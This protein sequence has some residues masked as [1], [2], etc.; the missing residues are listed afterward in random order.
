MRHLFSP[1]GDAALTAVMAVRPLLAFDFDGTLAP[2]VARPD[3]A[4][5]PLA[6]AWRLDRLARVLPLAIVS[7]RA[8]DDLRARLPFEPR[9]VIGNHGA[10]DPLA[11]GAV[12]PAALDDVRAQLAAA[13]GALLAAEVVVE[14]KRHSLALHYRL[15]HDRTRALRLITTFV[16]ELGPGVTAFGGKLVMNIV[17]TGAPDKAHAVASLVG[18]SAARAA[19]FLGDDVN[20]EP[21]F[22][23]AET[24]WLTVKVGRDGSASRA[25]Y[26]LDGLADVATMLDRMLGLM[27]DNGIEPSFARA[28]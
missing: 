28:P 12:D 10:E 22:A 4:R 3:A 13:A 6:V 8:V 11:P 7:G 20:D 16:A 9:Y 21:V 14:D 2:L 23:R 18:R 19:V 26:Y 5:I 1:E 17:P 25:M 27:G 15:A 24:G